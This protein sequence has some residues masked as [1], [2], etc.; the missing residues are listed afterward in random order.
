M[1]LVSPEEQQGGLKDVSTSVRQDE[2]LNAF[3]I[4]HFARVEVACGIH[5]DRIYPV[6][7]PGIASVSAKGPDRVGGE[8]IVKQR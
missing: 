2:F 7:L 4:L 5:S 6:K 1:G 8:F 3:S